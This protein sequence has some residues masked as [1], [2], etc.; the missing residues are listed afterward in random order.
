MRSSI[1]HLVLCACLGP[2]SLVAQASGLGDTLRGATSGGASPSTL[3]GMLGGG[4]APS[5]LSAM[6]LSESA[7]PSN[8]AGVITYCIKNNYLNA[9][10]AALVKQQLLGKMGLGAAQ[11][12][13]RDEG[14][15][16]GLSGMVSGSNGKQFNLNRLKGDLKEKA[17]DFVLDNASSLL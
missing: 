11:P 7:T 13:P 4:A 6:G 3:G 14:Y 9:D 15:L 8:A 17:C 16:S 5:A 12:E 10:K 2:V 1:R